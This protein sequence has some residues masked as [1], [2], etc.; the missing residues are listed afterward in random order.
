MG[1]NSVAQA[2]RVCGIP[3]ADAAAEEVL[4]LA[5]AW[6]RLAEVV[7][8][9]EGALDRADAVAEDS[10]PSPCPAASARRS[11][12]R[13]PGGS[14]SPARLTSDIIGALLRKGDSFHVMQRLFL[15]YVVVLAALVPAA[16]AADVT[17]KWKAN[18]EGPNGSME[19]TYDFQASG[20]TLT[21]TV[22]S[23]M[24]EEKIQEGKVK[25][26]EVTFLLVVGDGFRINYKGKLCPLYPSDAADELPCVDLGGCRTT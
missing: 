19:I 3:V 1:H 17:G 2:A 10:L 26:D 8:R 12:L 22:S 18:F 7:G 5:G 15:L 20:E 14:R 11:S 9:A 25:G 23:Q 6:G 24:G 16:P 21:G 13:P 4:G